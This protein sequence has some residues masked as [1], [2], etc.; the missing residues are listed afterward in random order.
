MTNVE[1]SSGPIVLPLS[2]DE[3]TL[4]NLCADAYTVAKNVLRNMHQAWYHFVKQV[5][6]LQR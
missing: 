5:R 4:S 6:E 1:A 3:A 2:V